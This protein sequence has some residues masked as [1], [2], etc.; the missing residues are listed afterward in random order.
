MGLFTLN[1]DNIEQIVTKPLELTQEQPGY[2]D[3]I[4][5]SFRQ[6]NVFGSIGNQEENLPS[7]LSAIAYD[8]QRTPPAK[9]Y[10]QNAID[11]GDIDDNYVIA[12][13]NVRT[14]D[15]YIAL[16]RQIAKEK[17]DRDYI[18]Q[19]DFKTQLLAGATAGLLDLDPLMF[20]P[21]AGQGAKAGRL[22]NI[23]LDAGKIATAGAVS[24][25]TSEYIL[26]NTQITRDPDNMTYAL[27]G[28][29]VFGGTIGASVGAFRKLPFD[30]EKLESD[31]GRVLLDN[32]EPD[33]INIPSLEKSLSAAEAPTT[34]L[35]EE[36][37]AGG[38][39]SQKLA[40]VIAGD[41]IA[42]DN[43]VIQT[44]TSPFKN[45]RQLSQQLAETS[46]LKIAKAEKGLAVGFG[47]ASIESLNK[48]ARGA[49]AKTT[50]E[51]R[52]LFVQMRLGQ[53]RNFLN[54]AR[55]EIADA[56]NKNNMNYRQFQRE[57][58]V[59]LRNGDQHTI[60]EVQKAAQS[61]RKN[62]FEPLTQRAVNL[63]ILPE[64]VTPETAASY[65]TRIYDIDAINR[66]PA[67]FAEITQKWLGEQQATKASLKAQ[68]TPLYE[69]YKGLKKD[70]EL[71]DKK[72]KDRKIAF[73]KSAGQLKEG[74]K[75][76][77]DIRSRLSKGENA[78][79]K[80]RNRY[81]QLVSTIIEAE[82]K[83]DFINSKIAT[84][85]KKLLPELNDKL[86][87]L[88]Q[89]KQQALTDKKAFNRVLR[90]VKNLPEKFTPS[91]KYPVLLSLK[92]MIHPD[93]RFAETLKAMDVTPK[94]FPGYF[95]REG[96]MDLD[97]IPFGELPIEIQN[98]VGDI[99]SDGYWDQNVLLDLIAD[100]MR[101]NP[102]IMDKDMPA[103]ERFQTATEIKAIMDE[104]FIDVNDTNAFEK[105]KE[106]QNL[107]EAPPPEFADFYNLD[108][109]SVDEVI[110]L[111]DEIDFY[112][113]AI[114][115]LPSLKNDIDKAFSIIEKIPDIKK[116]P[117]SKELRQLRDS[118]D[119]IES[120][121]KDF[122]VRRSDRQETLEKAETSYNIR[123]Q[124]RSII[125]NAATQRAIRRTKDFV[126]RRDDLQK[127]LLDNRK[128]KNEAENI[129]QQLIDLAQQWEGK[130]SKAIKSA[131]KADATGE[132]LA[133]SL[134]K[135]LEKIMNT[136]TDLSD[137]ELLLL[138]EEIRGRIVSTPDG[139]LPYA[140]SLNDDG[141]TNNNSSAY[142]DSDR[143]R[144][145]SFKGRVFAIPDNLIAD[146]TIN[147]ADIVASSYMKRVAPYMNMVERFKGD[148]NL[149]NIFKDIE[150]E[151]ADLLRGKSGAEAEKLAK[152]Y[153]R[154]IRNLVTLRNRALGIDF[155]PTDPASVGSRVHRSV[156][157][158]NVITLLGGMTIS[159]IP[160]LGRI[161]SLGSGLLHSGFK[162]IIK[163]FGNGAYLKKMT[164]LQDLGVVVELVS[165]NRLMQIGDIGDDVQ[166][167]TRVERAIEYAG[168][169][170]GIASG[171]SL[172]NETLKQI[173]ALVTEATI[174]RHSRNLIAGK[175]NADEITALANV[176]ID[177]A[178]A[179]RIINQFDQY[180]ENHKGLNLL[181]AGQWDDKQA[182]EVFL[183][184]LSQEVDRIIV[185]PGYDKSVNLNS[186]ELLK[187]L[188]Q[189]KTFFF[190]TTTRVL[191][192]GVQ[193]GA[194]VKNIGQFLTM[195][196]LGSMIYATK[197]IQA[198]RELSDNPAVWIIESFDRAG[199]GGI[200]MEVNNILEKGAGFGLRPLVGG[201]VASRYASRSAADSL[202]GPSYG[203]LINL[204]NI[205]RAL[206]T[207]EISE[208]DI[209]AMVRMIPGRNLPYAQPFI[210]Q[211]KE[212]LAET[213]Q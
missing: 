132:T 149:T 119:D 79:K 27:I 96:Q 110:D 151:Y 5:A 112:S 93:G 115:L 154:D 83:A 8:E 45:V 52:D 205:M 143:H 71:A 69:R 50:R 20:V 101:G 135:T 87:N 31:I 94:Q 130:S 35:A 150:R 24:A 125:N 40:Q 186:S 41:K 4:G 63:D 99:P 121:I 117:L 106:Y 155:M 210:N 60:P 103:F 134:D 123:E 55:L 138:A 211:L 44:L 120:Q 189:F 9:D 77:K 166:P 107:N 86:I 168:D 30:M 145:G 171:M 116:L 128:A 78:V 6:E 16:K 170:F 194:T 191:L 23:V 167:R 80:L 29:A 207:G 32:P 82:T 92:G 152:Q 88:F 146:F 113:R 124:E 179:K 163:N 195:M 141:T 190:A 26:Q 49:L 187:T 131:L 43:P 188:A 95:S 199:I 39:V 84:E 13:E 157:T 65:F 147:D 51:S 204:F 144:P 198:D 85:F 173:S 109:V 72:L 127:R 73:D 193:D 2:F 17:K 142:M 66:K 38:R 201:D 67:R 34:T 46:G 192:R 48:I 75:Y 175:A 159:A 3:I 36:G 100:E 11:D 176:R 12:F 98:A 158:F 174:L 14:D 81:D 213:L 53:K 160:D 28:G 182:K 197:T 70:S 148:V 61:Y 133:K 102:I 180:G 137:D 42:L 196:T 15:E 104:A 108:D 206:N 54:S 156:R 18:G 136:A 184:A 172:W 169:K 122:K 202:I 139:R 208:A 162:P 161:A 47:Q 59:A 25:G 33:G 91:V 62:V 126:Q 183:G 68:I 203:Q 58:G 114:E 37:L 21:F 164:E 185:T 105:I 56:F 177:E 76:L 111:N 97:N 19:A 181:N 129:Q 57:I 212:K 74:M 118:F 200:F 178:M 153:K 10:V 7:S 89:S 165:N 1:A 90:D 140:K 22:A 209:N 64:G